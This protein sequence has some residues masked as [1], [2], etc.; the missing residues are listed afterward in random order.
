MEFHKSKPALTRIK[1]F[2][3]PIS[4]LGGSNVKMSSCTLNIYGCLDPEWC[5][6]VGLLLP[7]NGHLNVNKVTLQST[8]PLSKFACKTFVRI[9]QIKI[10]LFFKNDEKYISSYGTK[11]FTL[12]L[13]L[14][15]LD[16]SNFRRDANIWS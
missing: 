5:I 16:W 6:H 12:H 8:I 1:S 9:L 10:L 13:F 7:S 14:E 2:L 11:N 3:S 15:L 4:S